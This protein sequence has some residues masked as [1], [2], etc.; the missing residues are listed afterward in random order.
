ML[1]PF[2]QRP[3]KKLEHKVLA[4]IDTAESLFD[5]DPVLVDEFL[6]EAES[7]YEK[8]GYNFNVECRITEVTLAYGR[9]IRDDF[10]VEQ[11]YA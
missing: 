3:N 11:Y 9:S 6:R 2:F 10:Q 7:L 4:L 5:K 1:F 8:L